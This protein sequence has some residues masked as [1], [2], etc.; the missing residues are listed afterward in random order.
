[1]ANFDIALVLDQTAINT[2]AATIY[3]KGKESL[4]KGSIDAEGLTIGWKVNSCPVINCK[5][6]SEQLAKKIVASCD[7]TG[8]YPEL[9]AHL[10]ANPKSRDSV[11]TVMATSDNLFTLSVQ[12]FELTFGDVAESVIVPV[13]ARCC[14][15]VRGVSVEINLLSISIN[16]KGQVN[17]NIVDK[18]II[19]RM[20]KILGDIFKGVSIPVLSIRGLNLGAT[21]V[22]IQNSRVIAFACLSTNTSPASIDGFNFPDC[23]FS[24]MLSVSSLQQEVYSLMNGKTFGPTGSVDIGIGSL[25]Y[26]ATVSVQN[27][28]ASLNGTNLEVVVGLNGSASGGLQ[29]G[30][31]YPTIGFNVYATPNPVITCS[32]AL[33]GD[34]VSIKASSVAPFAAIVVPT[35]VALT[36]APFSGLTGSAIA[37]TVTATLG[38]ALVQQLSLGSSYLVPTMPIKYQGLSVTVQAIN[39]SVNNASGY[40]AIEGDIHVA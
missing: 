29:V 18:F 40:L 13:I 10:E 16:V 28:Q 25:A 32:I 31:V 23:Q 2:M 4:F 24:A 37:S 19:P 9:I 17:Q 34:Q 12:S 21:Y 6:P 5:A 38:S 15:T 20:T 30:C 11:A 22:S 26:H 27:P 8:K 3:A 14:L 36:L 1:M 35:G 7:I 39:L 33:N